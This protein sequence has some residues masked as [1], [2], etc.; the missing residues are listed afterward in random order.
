MVLSPSKGHYQQLL[1]LEANTPREREYQTAL[2]EAEVREAHF[3][4]VIAGLQGAALLQGRYCDTLQS[5]LAAQEEKSR[6]KKKGRL[7][8]DGLPWLLTDLDFIMRVQNHE[9]A[10]EQQAA[11]LETRKANREVRAEAMKEW[12]K[13]DAERK[14]K[15]DEI[16]A[17]FKEELEQWDTERDRAKRAKQKPGWKKPTRGK[18]IP[19]IPKP[20]KVLPEP[21]DDAEPDESSDDNGDDDD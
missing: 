20:P 13:A 6:S 16:K 10:Q 15:N 17:R 14:K 5:Q 7:V 11:E 3:K 19:P 21:D 8:G 18:L 9:D 4:G 2:R 12:K 1:A